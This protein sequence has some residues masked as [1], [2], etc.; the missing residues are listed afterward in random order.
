MTRL[1]LQFGTYWV[2]NYILGGFNLVCAQLKCVCWLWT[3]AIFISQVTATGEASSP[4]LFGAVAEQEST[5]L[6]H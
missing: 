1:D 3:D 5:P 6:S 2:H 4:V